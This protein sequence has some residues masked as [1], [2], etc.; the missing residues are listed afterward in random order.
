MSLQVQLITLAAMVF[1]GHALGVIFDAYRVVSRELRLHRWLIP[2]CDLLYWIAATLL[3]FR[4]LYAANLGEIRMFVFLG[5]LL[6]ISMYFAFVSPWTVRA[7]KQLIE[8]IRRAIAL[9][10]RLFI[11]LIVRP[12]QFLYRC[13]IIFMGFLMALSVFLYKFVLQLLYPLWV[14]LKWITRPLHRHV[15]RLLIWMRPVKHWYERILTWL[16]IRK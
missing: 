6:G 7:V 16:R 4:V 3:V 1:S 9:G 8:I 10:I 12:L 5:I 13:L 2:A 11:L 15:A 14:I